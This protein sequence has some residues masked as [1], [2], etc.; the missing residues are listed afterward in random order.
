MPA[1]ITGPTPIAAAHSVAAGS[2]KRKGRFRREIAR[3]LEHGNFDDAFRLALGS[4]SERDILRLM[5]GIRGGPST[6][7]RLIGLETRDK[8]FAFVARAISAE[9]Y[10]EHALPWV[11]DIVQAGEAKSLPFAVRMQLA[12]ALHGLAASPTDQGVMAARLG[13]Y[14]SLTAVGRTS[15]NDAAEGGNLF[16]VLVEG[17]V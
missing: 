5:G 6:C 11:F 1:N 4:G 14:L 16:S 3:F 8:L 9:R 17:A 2:A 7:R 15:F 10:A 13:P 12:G